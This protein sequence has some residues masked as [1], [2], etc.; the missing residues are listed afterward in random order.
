MICIHKLVI[1]RLY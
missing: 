1:L